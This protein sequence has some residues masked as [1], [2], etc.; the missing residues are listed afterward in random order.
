MRRK[1]GVNA[2][3]ISRES[4]PETIA[5]LSSLGVNSF[6]T[7]G[8]DEKMPELKKLADKLGMD[9]E[10]VHGP[11]RGI[12]AFWAEGDGYKSLD[13]EIRRCI[14]FASEAGVP[15][16]ILHISSGWYPPSVNELG[17]SRFDSVVDYATEKGIVVA[18]ENLRNVENVL[19]F[20]QRYED[21]DFVRYCYDAGH[22]HCYTPEHDF[23]KSFGKKLICTHI[24][25]NLGFVDKTTDP[26]AHYLPFD[27]NLDY[28]EMI[29]RLDAVSYSGTLMLEVF[30]TTKQEYKELT[31]DEFIETAVERIKKIANM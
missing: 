12:N 20:M 19:Y 7:E 22:E 2:N 23:I 15:T 11:W 14:D 5:K 1:I 4:M 17:L 31:D 13:A 18:F 6:F 30:K 28:T 16:I 21:N 10:F 3:C 25:D 8:A 24:H 27:G 9:F 26:D 29:R